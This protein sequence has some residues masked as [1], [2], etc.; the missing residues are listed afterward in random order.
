MGEK[1]YG[2]IGYITRRVIPRWLSQVLDA[3]PEGSAP[4]EAL[5]AP[6]AETHDV[7]GKI[8]YLC[9]CIPASKHLQPRDIT[10]HNI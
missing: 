10:M 2:P 8:V 3:H 6:P 5:V 7:N 4:N 9:L 1:S